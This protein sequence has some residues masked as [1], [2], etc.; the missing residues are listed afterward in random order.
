[1]KYTVALSRLE[2]AFNAGDEV[3]MKTL[4]A[5]GLVVAG[6]LSSVKIVGTGELSKKLSVRVPVSASARAA[7][8]KAGGSLS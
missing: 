3:S 5:K 8:E 1:M 7:I 6:H 4:V 2:S